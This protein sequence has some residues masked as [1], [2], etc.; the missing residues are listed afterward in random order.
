MASTIILELAPLPVAVALFAL[1]T[2]PAEDVIEAVV[3]GFEAL[4]ATGVAA[5]PD[6]DEALSEPLIS[7][8]T[9]ELN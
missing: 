2:D 7:A 4:E 8:W 1:T 3:R 5:A 6:P 9:M